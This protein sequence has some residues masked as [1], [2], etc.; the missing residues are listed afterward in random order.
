[1]IPLQ[2]LNRWVPV[3]LWKEAAVYYHRFL[4]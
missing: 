4:E 3:S 1:M 2:V